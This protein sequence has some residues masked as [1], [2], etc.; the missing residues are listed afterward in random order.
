M[1]EY[2]DY[3]IPV[4]AY[5]EPE[6]LLPQTWRTARAFYLYRLR[7]LAISGLHA[8]IGEDWSFRRLFT[9][10]NALVVLWWV[11]LYWGE[12][13]VF[14]GNIESCN[15]DK[16]ENWVC[17]SWSVL[18]CYNLMLTYGIGSWRKSPQTHLRRRSATH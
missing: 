16:W 7:P 10:A 15:W 5:Q 1:T 11:V 4:G 14:N 13:G 3:G 6:G 9:L 8:L 12:S 2:D 17:Y 18:S